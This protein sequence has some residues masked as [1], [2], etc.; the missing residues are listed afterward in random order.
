MRAVPRDRRV[1]Q[2]IGGR[3]C[4]R[5]ARLRPFDGQSRAW[6]RAEAPKFSAVAF[7]NETGSTKCAGELRAKLAE[8][9]AGNGRNYGLSVMQYREVRDGLEIVEDSSHDTATP[10]TRSTD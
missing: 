2:A 7:L 10:L 8:L 3:A 6:T 1:P 9:R 5:L 4:Q